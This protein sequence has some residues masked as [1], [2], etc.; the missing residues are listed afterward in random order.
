MKTPSFKPADLAAGFKT[1]AFR[2]GGYSVASAVIVLA[3]AV[4]VN[5]LAGAVPAKYTQFDTTANGMFSISDQTEKLLSGMDSAVEIYWIVRDG[6]EDTAIELLLSRYEAL[7]GKIDVTVR[8]PDVY[9]AF[10]QQYTD[11]V[12]DNSLIVTSG[13]RW[14]Y[15][16]SMD[17]YEYDY[18]NYYTTGTYDIS[19]AGEG[20]ITSAI[21]YVLSDSLPVVYAL[22]GHGE[23]P[24][25]SSF[26]TA[27]QRE[28]IELRELSL[29]TV[30]AIPDDAG[31][32]LISIPQSDIS[33]Q[34][35]DM[36]L[37]YL[38]GG[39]KLFLITQ[40]PESGALMNL[41][42]LMTQYGITAETGIV[43]EGNQGYFAW[44]TPYYLLPDI[45]PHEITSPLTQNGYRVVL[46]IAQGL[47]VSPDIP[48]GVEVAELLTTSGAAFSKTAG[49]N[50]D[51]Y[52]KEDGDVSGPFALA[53]AVTE[54]L[55]GGEET[56]IVWVSSPS[57][58]DES[59]DQ[60]VSGANSDFFLNALGWMCRQE[61]SAISIRAK[62]LQT[63]MLA[64]SGAA[65]SGFSVLFVGVIPLAYLAAGIYIRMRRRHR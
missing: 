21:D 36:L 5:V 28:N 25:P 16:D 33:T 55:S 34:E 19:F 32:V 44:N 2:V 7:S 47:T 30:E 13:T 53:V 59:A 50:L 17:M 26:E 43:V 14:R 1:R 20:A 52:E 11:A 46:P 18:S 3:I 64:M 41:E 40:P 6:Y 65:S 42:S 45:G 37:E 58:I 38:Q 22:T 9:P 23:T 12:S 10:V 24:L 56:Q 4:L 62:S 35:G 39:G 31:A 29:L 57:L 54:E 15:V 49:W 48:D 27:V 8:D 60:M 61:D 63:E 51:T